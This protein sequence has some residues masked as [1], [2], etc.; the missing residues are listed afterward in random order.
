MLV[1]WMGDLAYVIGIVVGFVE[2][3]V[4]LPCLA[5]ANFL[6]LNVL[7]VG[8]KWY[9]LSPFPLRELSWV[10]VYVVLPLV[11]TRVFDVVPA[12]TVIWLVSILLSGVLGYYIAKYVIRRAHKS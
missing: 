2:G 9:Q 10:E 12:T 5:A 8:G 11:N 6:S 4:T 1:V 7:E 3:L